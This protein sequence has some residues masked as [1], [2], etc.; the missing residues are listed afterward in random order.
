MSG[1][2]DLN[3]SAHVPSR[4]FSTRP[5]V[6]LRASVRHTEARVRRASGGLSISVGRLLRTSII[7][8]WDVD[9]SAAPERQV[10]RNW[11]LIRLPGRCEMEMPDWLSRKLSVARETA[12]SV[13]Y[14]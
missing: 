13:L 10:E 2:L 7:F 9:A 1:Q 14:G 11:K 4:Q 6:I 5:A 3:R 8:R 12:V